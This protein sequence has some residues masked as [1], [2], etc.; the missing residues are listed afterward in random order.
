M[1]HEDDEESLVPP[2]PFR[3]LG[4]ALGRPHGFQVLGKVLKLAEVAR[5]G[6]WVPPL[7]RAEPQRE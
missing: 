6:G 4:A 2:R 5:A 3:R 7:V 1:I